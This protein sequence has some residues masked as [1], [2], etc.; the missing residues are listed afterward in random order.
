MSSGNKL[1]INM[2]FNFALKKQNINMP[3]VNTCLFQDQRRNLISFLDKQQ[4]I[5]LK[6]G[7]KLQITKIQTTKYGFKFASYTET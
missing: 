4:K 5:Q 1:H 7:A 2:K 6:N 3:L